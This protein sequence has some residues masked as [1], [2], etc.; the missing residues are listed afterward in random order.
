MKAIEMR[1]QNQRRQPLAEAGGHVERARRTVAQQVDTLQRAAQFREQRVYLFADLDAATSD[2]RRHCGA[3]PPDN[4]VE[5][6]D[7]RIVSLF[8]ARRAHSSSW[9][10]TP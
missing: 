3:V 9:L 7:I 1:R 10:V 5:H 8:L 2:Q 6:T 4:R